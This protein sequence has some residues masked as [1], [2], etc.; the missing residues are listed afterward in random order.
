MTRANKT[1]KLSH[2]KQTKKFSCDNKFYTN[3]DSKTSWWLRS[4]HN[5]SEDMNGTNDNC[6]CHK[7]RR[8][9]RLTCCR[10]DTT[11][12]RFKSSNR[13]GW[14]L[15]VLMVVLWIVVPFLSAASVEAVPVDT[16][17]TTTIPSPHA[18]DEVEFTT[19]ITPQLANIQ[20][21]VTIREN[22]SDQS[23]EATNAEIAIV[24]ET[25]AIS[26]NVTSTNHSNSTISLNAPQEINNEISQTVNEGT[27]T[28]VRDTP[29][30]IN[31]K[32]EYTE[33][34]LTGNLEE[35]IRNSVKN[36]IEFEHDIGSAV[37]EHLQQAAALEE[38]Q[39]HSEELSAE[40]N[41]K[42]HDNAE[43]SDAADVVTELTSTTTVAT[44]S[45]SAGYSSSAET[46][47][48]I[49][50]PAQAEGRPTT[51]QNLT[52]SQRDDRNLNVNANE[53]F[54]I[55]NE[56]AVAEN[57]INED[58]EMQNI[59]REKNENHDRLLGE[60]K[61]TTSITLD[62]TCEAKL[63]THDSNE[64]TEDG[65]QSHQKLDN[66]QENNDKADN[67]SESQES[68]YVET[69][70]RDNAE[71]NISKL[72]D[73]LKESLKTTQKG[74]ADVET[75]EE[76]I[77]TEITPVE[78]DTPSLSIVLN[79]NLTATEP[80][81]ALENAPLEELIHFE[82][83]QSL[84][85]EQTD[86]TV[87]PE[88]VK[89]A[90]IVIK[91]PGVELEVDRIEPLH[92]EVQEKATITADIEQE[93]AEANENY[94]EEKTAGTTLNPLV[95]GDG[96]EKLQGIQSEES[97]NK[98][99]ATQL[100][101][102]MEK[103]AL[104]EPLVNNEIRDVEIN[105]ENDKPSEAEYKIDSAQ[106]EL[107]DPA[108]QKIDDN[109]DATTT[110][111]LHAQFEE[112]ADDL[113]ENQYLIQASNE[114]DHHE[115]QSITAQTHAVASELTVQEPVTEDSSVE[116][117]SLASTTT[118]QLEQLH[119][120]L[121]STTPNPKSETQ[122]TATQTSTESQATTA[123]KEFEAFEDESNSTDDP[124]IVPIL[125]GV[126]AAQ[127]DVT[128]STKGSRSI[129]KH[130]PMLFKT[131]DATL[132]A[133]MFDSF[134]PQDADQMFN[135]HSAAESGGIIGKPLPA[136][137][138]SEVIPS[139]LFTRSGLIIVVCSIFAFMFV[140]ASVVGF[141]ISFQ[142]QHGTLDIEMQEQ[143]CGKDNLDEED[144]EAGTCTRLLEVELPKSSIVTVACEEMEECL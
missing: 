42:H 56:N 25:E 92:I 65:V 16:N 3:L 112:K 98:E 29:E 33:T 72:S 19:V 21:T 93:Q 31:P 139:T 94:V 36:E 55:L 23:Q 24:N 95:E 103:E 43:Q 114:L 76:H 51:E 26:F 121:F 74:I 140:L 14:Q 116:S 11:G 125:V 64:I 27:T 137:S 127:G 108:Q 130:H 18:V 22:E 122:G 100:E 102:K 66:S 134:P 86:T 63:Y 37:A 7:E 4:H 40:Q 35:T 91:K 136:R 89:S 62:P 57:E 126:S 1:T 52:G 49:F 141:L 138:V 69:E 119:I 123:A 61:N 32:F 143:R 80:V 34:L 99:T 50:F 85:N 5:T 67:S 101:L 115:V 10:Y 15:Y 142:R 81:E 39:K 20:T 68:I 107:S 38:L 77:A 59:E 117:K 12:S 78:G 109:T 46:D 104:Y 6:S 9:N 13:E 30:L 110:N 44:D 90:H 45:T 129:N 87:E 75:E 144:E 53:N 105:S 118:A 73:D 106:N 88:A 8:C 71:I 128:A 131:V 28:E 133:V 135:D 2:Q 70:K 111:E 124:N 48:S 97:T 84:L 58:G 41:A 54:E 120:S 60:V 47:L 113:K 96:I 83:S 79:E 132:A 17:A 82:E